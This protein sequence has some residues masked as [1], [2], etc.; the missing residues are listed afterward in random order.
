MSTDLAELEP[1]LGPH[2][3]RWWRQ[4]EPQLADRAAAATGLH[5]F[6]DEAGAEETAALQRDPSLL[7]ALA[8]IFACSRFLTEAL[9]QSPSL[10]LWLDRARR[11]PRG[12]V[13]SWREAL[14]EFAVEVP[15]A[16]RARRLTR[17]RRR[18]Y[19]RIVLRDVQGVAS[20]AET[21]QELS[22]LAAAILD[23][24]H[25]WAWNDLVARHG[26]PGDAGEMAEMTVLGLGKLGGDELNY[27]SDIDLMFV[28]TGRAHGETIGDEPLTHRC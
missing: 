6:L 19:L 22:L 18:E 5:R 7:Q 4:L 13:E 23:Q 12:G 28:H 25:A 1:R 20:L 2:L 17:F 26:T 15:E 11:E 3:A 16:D 10:L 27:S 9:V 14:A 24:A 8:A 21:T